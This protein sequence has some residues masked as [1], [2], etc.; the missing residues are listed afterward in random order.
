[1]LRH[2]YLAG[3]TVMHQARQS[4]M[5]QVMVRAAR[6]AARPFP[7]V[8]VRSQELAL[9]VDPLLHEAGVTF[10]LTWHFH[11][12]GQLSRRGEEQTIPQVGRVVMI[13]LES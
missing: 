8:P 12:A 13:L 5:S 3:H 1:M 10:A 2:P 9:V 6:R 11:P 4:S 7:A